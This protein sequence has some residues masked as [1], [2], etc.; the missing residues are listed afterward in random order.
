MNLGDPQ[1]CL[2]WVLGLSDSSRSSENSV[3]AVAMDIILLL[4]AGLE[5]L[6]RYPIWGSP[7]KAKG[8]LERK[9]TKN[10]H[11]DLSLFFNSQASVC[12]FIQLRYHGSDPQNDV[13]NCLGLFGIIHSELL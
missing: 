11:R 9:A 5:K 10:S 4:H 13:S 1:F 2:Q 8:R 6:H 7:G 12:N 3:L